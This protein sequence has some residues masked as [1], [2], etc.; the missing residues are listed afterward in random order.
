MKRF[1]LAAYPLIGTKNKP[2]ALHLQQRSPYYWWWA[3]LRRNEEYLACCKAGGSGNLAGVY[4]DFGDVRRDDFRAWWGGKQQR[5]TY[6]FAEQPLPLKLQKLSTKADWLPE[7]EQQEN[8]MVIALNMDVGRRRL[9][10][11]FADVLKREHSGKRGRRAMRSIHST[12]LY[13][14]YRNFSVHSLK[15]VLSAYDVWQAN[16]QLPA[17]KRQTLWQMGESIKLVQSAITKK[18]DPNYAHKRNVM[19]AAFSRSVT[20]AKR[21]IANTAKSQFPNSDL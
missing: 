3:Y 7:W 13:P 1:F 15:V 5:G 18:N 17:G 4:K 14:L 2:A 20:Q 10:A 19:A 11:N 8:V 6:L 16:E 9:Q 12:A 21:I